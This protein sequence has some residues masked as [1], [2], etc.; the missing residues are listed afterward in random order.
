MSDGGGRRT[1]YGG[2][3]GDNYSIRL[4]VV[5]GEVLGVVVAVYNSWVIP[6]GSC[7]MRGTELRCRRREKILRRRKKRR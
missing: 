5:V 1:S 6:R 3:G 7:T 4:V 2:D